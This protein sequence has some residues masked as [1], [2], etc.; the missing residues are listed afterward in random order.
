MAG[1]VQAL[2]TGQALILD[3]DSAIAAL[4]ASEETTSPTTAE[5]NAIVTAF[6]ALL[7]TLKANGL[8]KA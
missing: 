5:H 4:T 7:V 6:N 3:T 1:E 2:V 8:I